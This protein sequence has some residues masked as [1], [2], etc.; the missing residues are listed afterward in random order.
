MHWTSKKMGSGSLTF[1]EF[2]PNKV[3]RYELK[4][5]DHKTNL[6]GNIEF[7]SAGAG[8]TRV[9][10]YDDVDMGGN[11]YKRLMGPMLKRML[12][13]AFGQNLAG[14]KTAAMTGKAS[15]PGPK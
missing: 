1:T 15:G 2:T 5:V 4:M 12:G 11:P 7:E 8:A 6:Q 3:L 10:W 9:S 14:L 13:Q